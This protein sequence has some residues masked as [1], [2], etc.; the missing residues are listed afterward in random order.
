MVALF[1]YPPGYFAKALRCHAKTP[2]GICCQCPIGLGHCRRAEQGAEHG[3]RN[4]AHPA[5]GSLRSDLL[6]IAFLPGYP[7]D[8]ELQV[9]SA[10]I[11]E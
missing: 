10:V 5:G 9:A 4:R 1:G 6:Q 11:Y 2:C 3:G 8:E 7:D